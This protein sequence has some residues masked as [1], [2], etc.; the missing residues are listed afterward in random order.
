MSDEGTASAAVDRAAGSSGGRTSRPRV[1]VIATGGTIDSLGTDRLD[2]AHYTETRDRL[3]DGALVASLPELASIAELV[4]VPYRRVPSYALTGTDWLALARAVRELV[5]GPDGVDGVVL[6]HGT[7]TLEETAF[8][9][10]LT[11]GPGVPVVLT[12]AMR[13]AS[14]LGADGTLNL[15]RAVQVAASPRARGHGVLVV[16]DDTVHAARHVTKTATFRVGAFRSPDTGPVGYADADGTVVLYQHPRP[17]SVRFDPADVNDLPRVDVLVSHV[18]ADGALIDAAVAA[19]ARGL[20]SAGTGAGRATADEDLAYNRAVAAGVVV[21][22][23]SRVGG[24]RVA[25]SPSMAVRGLVTADNLPAWKARILLALAL[26][27]TTD[28]GAIQHLFDQV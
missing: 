10:Q 28:P 26:T 21:C 19:G 13:P 5:A 14:G 1:A 25:R 11:I 24:G 20:V 16:L 12:G 15:V 7:N 6:T 18:G 8:W 4:E 27:R 22:Q 3:S 17:T 2:L 9:L 23:A